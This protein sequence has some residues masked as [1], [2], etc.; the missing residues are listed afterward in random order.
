METWT[1]IDIGNIVVRSIEVFMEI[2]FLSNLMERKYSVAKCYIIWET[3]MV[4]DIVICYIGVLPVLFKQLLTFSAYYIFSRVLHKNSRGYIFFCIMILYELMLLN[5][6]LVAV[7]MPFVFPGINFYQEKESMLTGAIIF[8][9]FFFI[10]ASFFG[11]FWKMQR[12]EVFSKSIFLTLLLPISHCIL[13]YGVAFYNYDVFALVQSDGGLRK[14]AMFM[15][16]GTVIGFLAEILIL[17]VT[18]ENSK[19][20]RMKVQLEILE[21]QHQQEL[22]YYKGIHEGIQEMRKIRHDFNNQLQT[23]YHIFFHE[24][25]KEEA[26]EL[27]QQLEH[28]INETF[29]NTGNLNKQE[30]R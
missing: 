29:G 10:S 13:F 25:R 2:V 1:M 4:A 9:F 18:F 21:T 20:E 15:L 14:S 22:S 6:L 26:V 23:A 3:A 24:D 8:D 30:E 27:L 28:Q 19:K 11:M 17:H 5:E 12:Q 16:I 7:C